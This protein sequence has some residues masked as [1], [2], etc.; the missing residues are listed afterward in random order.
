MVR[1]LSASVINKPKQT[2]EINYNQQKVFVKGHLNIQ[3]GQKLEIFCRY[4][5]Q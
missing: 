4:Q 3:I 1:I 5:N 2:I